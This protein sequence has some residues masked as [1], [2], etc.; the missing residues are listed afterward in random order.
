M[1]CLSVP[2]LVLSAYVFLPLFA[3]SD[4]LVPYFNIYYCNLSN[5]SA[6]VKGLVQFCLIL[7]LILLFRVL[8]ST[9]VRVI[10]PLLNMASL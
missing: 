8:G 1:R 10:V 7:L 3:L 9:A 4:G 6:A 2:I 5:T